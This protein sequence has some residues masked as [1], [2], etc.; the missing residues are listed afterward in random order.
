[1]FTR[2]EQQTNKKNKREKYDCINLDRQKNTVP[3]VVVVVDR[4][5]TKILDA[6]EQTNEPPIET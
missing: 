6:N 5:A 4:N 2:T 3:L 1:M